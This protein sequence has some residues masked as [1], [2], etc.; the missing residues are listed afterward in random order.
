MFYVVWVPTMGIPRCSEI[1]AVQPVEDTKGTG[2]LAHCKM[3]DVNN[4]VPSTPWSAGLGINK[5]V[6]AS[7]ESS[8]GFCFAVHEISPQYVPLDEE[9]PQLPQDSY[10]LSKL[11][12]EEMGAT[13]NRRTGMQ[14][15]SMRLGNVITPEMYA[16]FPGIVNDPKQKIRNLWNYIDARDAGSACRLAIEVEGLCAVNLNITANDNAMNIKSRVLMK[17]AF[18]EVKDFRASLEGFETLI[19][20]DKAKRLLNW[21]PIHSWRNNIK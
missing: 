11:I 4:P 15:V 12:A 16:H 21:E 10:G 18:P 19:S 20:N 13:F 17:S 8:Y 6:L 1:P 7:S 9:H 14:V 5:V 3:Q 2:V